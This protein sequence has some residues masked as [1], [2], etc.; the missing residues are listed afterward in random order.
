M[1]SLHAHLHACT[2]AHLHACTLAHVHACTLAHQRAMAAT[3]LATG[4]EEW[5]A[6]FSIANSGTYNNQWMVLDVAR[7]K[8]LAAVRDRAASRKIGGVF[9]MGIFS[10]S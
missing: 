3:T 10:S 6:I 4:G 7:F 9:R 1:L 5:V 2:R 8:A